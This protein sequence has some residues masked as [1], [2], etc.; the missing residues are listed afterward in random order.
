[1]C[2]VY[3]QYVYSTWTLYVQY[4]YSLNT[5]YVQYMHGI[6]THK[7]TL[8]R[9]AV[10]FIVSISKQN[11]DF[12]CDK[13]VVRGDNKWDTICTS[14][15]MTPGYCR[16]RVRREHN[17]N[18]SSIQMWYFLRRRLR[19]HLRYVFP[20]SLLWASHL[21]WDIRADVVVYTTELVDRGEDKGW[22]TLCYFLLAPVMLYTRV[23]VDMS[24]D[25]SSSFMF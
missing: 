16:L 14:K 10:L 1:M 22:G 24:E 12:L 9:L 8:L 3:A 20:V 5:V 18:V 6:C 13:S 19:H 17:L 15:H 4:M 23:S 2:T 7:C 11:A 21:S 25:I